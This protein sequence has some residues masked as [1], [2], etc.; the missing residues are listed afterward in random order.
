MPAGVQAGV[1]RTA[2]I[3]RP[4]RINTA[5]PSR[6]AVVLR[7]GRSACRRLSRL[8]QA[9]AAADDAVDSS[10]KP[11]YPEFNEKIGFI[12]TPL[13]ERVVGD[14]SPACLRCWARSA[15]CC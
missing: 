3:W 4:L 8:E 10:S 6:G 1:A 7:C 15:S 13:H 12:L 5:N 2:E 9:Q 11:A 14:I